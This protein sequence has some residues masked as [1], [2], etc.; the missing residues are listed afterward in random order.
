[1]SEKKNL[2]GKRRLVDLME[3]IPVM[4]RELTQKELVMLEQ[5]YLE[6]DEVNS[7]EVP[8][9]SKYLKMMECPKVLWGCKEIIEKMY[10]SPISIG[11]SRNHKSTNDSTHDRL[12]DNR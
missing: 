12:P 7:D 9:F 5:A 8:D 4:C 10:R 1:M 2:K 11:T 6:D 3:Y